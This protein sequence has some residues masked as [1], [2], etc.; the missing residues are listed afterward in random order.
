[1]RALY[2]FWDAIDVSENI[3]R[4]LTAVRG[5]RGL[6]AIV[7]AL[8]LGI[9]NYGLFWLIL[10]FDI[11]ATLEWTDEAAKS[12]DRALGSST[13]PL[14]VASAAGYVVLALTLL[15]TLVELFGAR[16]AKVGI[17]FASGLVFAFSLFDMIT[18]WPRV[19]EFF[20]SF[21]GAAEEAG[22]IGWALFYVLRIG[23][24]FMASFGFEA[25]F[26]I[27][28]VCIL[29]LLLQSKDSGGRGRVVAEG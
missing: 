16:F 19:A 18:D 22:I 26:I 9:I 14:E 15:P 13:I 17:A 7:L 25:L 1:M 8:A 28:S 5:V 27:F 24:L 21:R 10:T 4:G 12:V 29:A 23:W 2:A 3:A 20:D 11:G 6:N